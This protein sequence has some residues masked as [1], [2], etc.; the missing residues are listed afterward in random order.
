MQISGD[1][2]VVVAAPGV[3]GR[4]LQGWCEG[5]INRLS[6]SSIQTPHPSHSKYIARYRQ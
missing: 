3:L 4:N 2:A 1:F 6:E 5:Q